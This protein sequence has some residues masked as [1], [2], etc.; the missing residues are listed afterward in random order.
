M[1]NGAR[2][3]QDAL[4]DSSKIVRNSLQMVKEISRWWTK[5]QNEKTVPKMVSKYHPKKKNQQ[6]P[7][8][9]KN[10][11]RYIE[12]VKITIFSGTPDGTQWGTNKKKV[13]RSKNHYLSG[14][15]E[16]TQWVTNQMTR[17]PI[18]GAQNDLLGHGSPETLR[19][20]RIVRR[21]MFCMVCTQKFEWG[22]LAAG[23]GKIR[24]TRRGEDWGTPY[25][26][27]P[28]IQNIILY[29]IR[30]SRRVSA[31][32]WP[33]TTT[34]WSFWAIFTVKFWIFADFG[35]EWGWWAA[36]R[37]EIRPTGR[38]EV[39]GA[40]DFLGTNRRKDHSQWHS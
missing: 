27:V 38:C 19:D 15:P 28:I 4:R 13:H 5:D 30:A 1:G 31:G 34:L 10:N 11:Q 37:E 35:P 7:K 17:L 25:F 24:P 21:M 22:W 39:R 6:C 3:S 16:G 14:N 36:D 9:C 40:L 2:R 29:E 23:Q 12:V 26:G 33:K 32:S 18:W 20:V 8:M